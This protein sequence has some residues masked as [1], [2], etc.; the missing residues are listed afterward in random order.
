MTRK[1]RS[2]G[3]EIE[4]NNNV[5]RQAIDLQEHLNQEIAREKSRMRKKVIYAVFMLSAVYVVAISVFHFI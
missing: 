2:A 5:L 3:Y 4:N 1:T